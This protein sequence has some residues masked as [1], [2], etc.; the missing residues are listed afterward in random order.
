MEQCQISLD[1]IKQVRTTSPILA[2]PDPDMP[3]YLF[4]DSS[5]H[6]WSR[7]LTQYTEQT[8][9]DGTK[10]Q[11]LDPITYQSGTFQGFPKNWS[12]LRKKVFVIYTSFHKMVF[13]LK[14]THVMVEC[15][16]APLCKFIYSVTKNDKANNWSQEIRSVT[17]YI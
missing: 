16:H 10:I 1:H 11:I 6:S 7:I 8:K 4:I 9:G 5:K 17:P 13:Y 12:T 15:D 2:Y 14:D 3:H